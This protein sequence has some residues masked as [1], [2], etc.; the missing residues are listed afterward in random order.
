M[1]IHYVY[2]LYRPTGEPFYFGFGNKRRIYSHRSEA[3]RFPDRATPKIR[4][5]QKIWRNGLE[6]EER[7]LLCGLSEKFAKKCERMLIAKYGRMD[8]GTG[9]LANLTDG[10]D[11][12][13][14]H[15]EETIAKMTAHGGMR[16]KHHSEASIKRISEGVKNLP[17]EIIL[18]NQERAREAHKIKK[19]GTEESPHTKLYLQSNKYHKKPRKKP[20]H[21]EDF[22]PWNRGKKLKPLSKYHRENVSIGMKLYREQHPLSEE[23][24]EHLRIH[25]IGRHLSDEDRL[26]YNTDMEFRRYILD[27]RATKKI[28]LTS[29]ERGRKISDGHRRRKEGTPEEPYTKLYLKSSQYQNVSKASRAQEE[30]YLAKQFGYVTETK[31]KPILKPK[32]VSK[33]TLKTKPSVKDNLIKKKLPTPK[34]IKIKPIKV[35]KRGCTKRQMLLPIYN[36]FC[37]WDREEFWYHKI[38]RANAEQKRILGADWIIK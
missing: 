2:G 1:G 23:E 4:I 31:S 32:K 8:I 18:R 12:P 33:T 29:V 37:L 27:L 22:V 26:R 35:S 16:N 19:F 28:N 24:I 17:K 20:V 13:P 11:G 9:I 6:F 14:N 38:I 3:N 25:T 10:G 21:A 7:K 15:N 34:L 36:E 30:R 5:I